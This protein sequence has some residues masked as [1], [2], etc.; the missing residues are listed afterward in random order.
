MRKKKFRNFEKLLKGILIIK[1]KKNVHLNNFL[2]NK[3]P[4]IL[5]E[6]LLNIQFQ[7]HWTC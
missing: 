4:K 6:E 2:T 7:N 1:W 3:A 5:Q